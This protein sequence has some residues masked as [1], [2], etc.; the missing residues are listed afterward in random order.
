MILE[1]EHDLTG[2]LDTFG[3]MWT[4]V[5]GEATAVVAALSADEIDLLYGQD[6]S[7]GILKG[8]DTSYRALKG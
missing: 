7:Y 4:W 2:S 3:Q 1:L 6:A 5:S 8:Q